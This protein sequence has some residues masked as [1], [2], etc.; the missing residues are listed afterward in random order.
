VREEEGY[1]PRN[2]NL[3]CSLCVK[4]IEKNHVVVYNTCGDNMSNPIASALVEAVF[5]DGL[6]CMVCGKR[7]ADNQLVCDDCAVAMLP[8]EGPEH[9]VWVYMGAAAEAVRMLKYRDATALAR[10]IGLQMAALSLKRQL[11]ADVLVPVPIYWRR[12]WS[13]G[14]NQA[15]LLA[16]SMAHYLNLPVDE[17]TLVRVRHTPSQAGLTREQRLINLDGAFAVRDQALRGKRI[18]LVDDVT[19]TGATLQVCT[20]VLRQAGTKQVIGITACR[21][22]E[23]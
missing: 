8:W 19:T 21:T 23:T 14:Y 13:R 2:R 15:R 10:P 4:I 9:A 12:R 11:D 1:R 16:D 3:W 20:Q 6:V 17:K 22:D 18:L 7:Q 5:P